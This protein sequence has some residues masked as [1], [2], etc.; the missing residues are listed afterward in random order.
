MTT[1][2]PTELT[3]TMDALSFG[4]FA[5][6]CDAANIDPEQAAAGAIKMTMQMAPALVWVLKRR[7]EPELTLE[8]VR[9]GGIEVMHE[10]PALLAA[11]AGA[12]QASEAPASDA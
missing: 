11:A 3:F 9:A 2:A 10:L 5:D 6:L 1:T 7:N 8:A 12:E 4:E